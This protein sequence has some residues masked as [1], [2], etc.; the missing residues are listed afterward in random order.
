[1]KT[2]RRHALPLLFA[3][4]LAVGCN[5]TAHSP[6]SSSA[7]APVSTN[8]DKHGPPNLAEYIERLQSPERVADL[9]V[10]KVIE[11]LKLAADAQVGDLGCGPGIFSIAFAKACPRGVVFASDV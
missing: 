3:F 4:A 1:M 2:V 7:T 5:T 6:A 11:K 9:A 10:D 8:R